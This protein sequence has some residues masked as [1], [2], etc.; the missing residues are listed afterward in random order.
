MLFLEL[1]VVVFCQVDSLAPFAVPKIAVGAGLEE[2]QQHASPL[3]AGVL[4]HN[5]GSVL[6]RCSRRR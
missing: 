2:C 6:W 1:L 4:V 3:E 5:L